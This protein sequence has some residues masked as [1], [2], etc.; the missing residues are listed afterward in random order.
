MLMTKTIL[1]NLLHKYSTRLHPVE[2]RIQPAGARGDLTL[3]AD[4]CIA[5]RIC[6]NKCPTKVI[7]V[8]PEAGLWEHRVMGCLYCGVCVDACPTDCLSMTNRYRRPI[9]EPAFMR[10]NVKPRPKK[11]KEGATADKAAPVAVKAAPADK[12]APAVKAPP[13]DKAAKEK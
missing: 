9:T 11:S 10:C 4:K 8:D 6:A 1:G 7:R 2:E 5:C 12:A 13:A 3:A